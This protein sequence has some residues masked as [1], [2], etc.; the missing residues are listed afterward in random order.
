M[1]DFK[2]LNDSAN[3][4]LKAK[5]TERIPKKHKWLW[6]GISSGNSFGDEDDDSIS[7]GDCHNGWN[8]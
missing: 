5:K 8:R 4:N 1:N 6:Q 3:L 2:K 7:Y